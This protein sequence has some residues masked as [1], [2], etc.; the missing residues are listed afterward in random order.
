MHL[1]FVPESLCFKHVQWSSGR[2]IRVVKLVLVNHFV[3]V[4]KSAVMKKTCSLHEFGLLIWCEFRL[5]ID[6]IDG[7]F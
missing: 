7:A 5:A 1:V 4:K 3:Q 6:V 2:Q